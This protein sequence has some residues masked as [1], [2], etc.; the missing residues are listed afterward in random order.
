M[1]HTFLTEI[2][3]LIPAKERGPNLQKKGFR[4]EMQT[5]TLL[6]ISIHQQPLEY[7]IEYAMS[8]KRTAYR[9]LSMASNAGK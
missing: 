6:L 1:I 4:R 7:N 8:F 3:R 5:L 9:T 2:S